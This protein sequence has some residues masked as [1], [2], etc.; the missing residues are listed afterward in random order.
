M[1][2]CQSDPIVQL[3]NEKA[4]QLMTAAVYGATE[5]VR[6]LCASPRLHMYIDQPCG[7]DG[8]TVLI[9]STEAGRT[10]AS[11]LLIDAGA[12]ID[13]RDADGRTAL[14]AAAW[15]GEVNLV[16]PLLSRPQHAA[17][18]FLRADNGWTALMF[19]CAEGHVSWVSALLEQLTQGGASPEALIDLIEYEERHDG[20]SAI[21]LAREHAHSELVSLLEARLVELNAQCS[22]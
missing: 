16:A 10:E 19:A 17:N 3:A 20:R 1:R 15:Q 4:D 13:A 11:I 8:K 7:D 22:E 12:E 6:E 5:V 2:L 18:V 21:G 14:M 9:A